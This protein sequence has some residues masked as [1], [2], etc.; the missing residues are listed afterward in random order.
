[1]ANHSGAK[2]LSTSSVRLCE[3]KD[4]VSTSNQDEKTNIDKG[5]DPTETPTLL[6]HKAGNDSEV[7]KMVMQEEEPAVL[8][9]DSGDTTKQ[10]DVIT[11]Q[12]PKEVTTNVAKTGKES[13][14]DLL[15]AM[16]VEVTN[17]RKLKNLKVQQNFS[18]PKTKPAAMESTISMFQKA[19]LEASSQR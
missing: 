5:A 13:L 15:G 16:K 11:G 19:T 17:K 3:K 12:K 8:Q 18:T 4:S 6:K 10:M 14:L 7:I 2:S 1:M 9:T